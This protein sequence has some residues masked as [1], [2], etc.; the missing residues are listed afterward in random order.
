MAAFQYPYYHAKKYG[1][2]GIGMQYWN[3]T[4]LNSMVVW[5]LERRES[6]NKKRTGVTR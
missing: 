1:S 4:I 6:F 3:T 5:V 2:M